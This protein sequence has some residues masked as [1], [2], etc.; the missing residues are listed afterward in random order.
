MKTQVFQFHVLLFSMLSLATAQKSPG[1]IK[2]PSM[3]IDFPSCFNDLANAYKNGDG[4][5]KLD[6][7]LG[8][9]QAYANDQ[10]CIANPVLTFEQRT[11]F[12]KIACSCISL[13]GY[14]LLSSLSSSREGFVDA[15]MPLCTHPSRFALHPCLFTL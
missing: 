12:N 9:I 4:G 2:G 5:V 13:A 1:I 6:E 8:F 11:A 3:A 7:Y 14:V 15:K 10:K